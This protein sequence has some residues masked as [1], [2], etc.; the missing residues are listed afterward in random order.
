MSVETWVLVW[1][2]C[3]LVAVGAFAIMSVAVSIG[4]AYDLR[5]LFR[6]LADDD[7]S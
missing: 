1:K 7:R 2:I 4:G 6:Q 5:R 3:L